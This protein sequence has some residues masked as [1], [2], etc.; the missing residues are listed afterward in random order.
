MDDMPLDRRRAM[1]WD[2]ERAVTR[3]YG[4]VDERRYDE[5]A[6]QYAPA[7]VWHRQ[8]KALAGRDAI[9]AAL[10]A[11]TS[12][13]MTRHL[14]TNFTVNASGPGAARLSCYLNTYVHDS[15]TEEA[16]PVAMRSPTRFLIVDASLVL[17]DGRWL[18]AEIRTR[19]EFDFRAA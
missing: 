17:V 16:R 1:E 12:T 13:Q 4:G 6:A 19:P 11:R 9:L 7:G 8:G 2:C 3:M 5:V 18:I 10:N 14:L 15:G